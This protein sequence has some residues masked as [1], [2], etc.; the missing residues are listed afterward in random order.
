MSTVDLPPAE[1]QL[2]KQLRAASRKIEHLTE[3]LRESE[4]SS[5]RLS[6]QAKLLKEEIRRCV[7]ILASFPDSHQVSVRVTRW[8]PRNKARCGEDV[9]PSVGWRETRRE[10][11]VSPT[12]SI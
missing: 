6:D 11:K 8:E 1:G 4:A 9:C 12:W 2:H 7:N 10:N 5:M 3:L